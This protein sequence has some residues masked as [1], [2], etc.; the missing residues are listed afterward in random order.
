MPAS[1]ITEH[2]MLGRA[3]GLGPL[4]AAAFPD[5]DLRPLLNALLA[6]ETG[7]VSL[8]AGDARAPVGHVAFTLCMEGGGRTVALLGPLAVSPPHQRRGIGRALVEAGCARMAELGAARVCVLGDPA[9]YAR[10]GF[11]PE[12]EIAAPYALPDAW[13]EAWQSRALPG[14]CAGLAGRLVVP[15]PWRDPALWSS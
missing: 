4:Y 15:S 12:R 13:R 14:N 7:V 9:Y 5:E 1:E 6:E 11:Q 2:P 8:V 10:L 3:H